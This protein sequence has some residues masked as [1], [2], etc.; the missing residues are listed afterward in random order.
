MFPAGAP[1]IALLVL[2]NCI[3]IALAG[4]AFPVGWQHA[5]FLVLLSMLCFGLFT[6]VV[7]G[8][9]VAALLFHPAHSSAVFS[10]NIV[11]LALSALSLALLG[12]GAFSIDARIFGRRVLVSTASSNSDDGEQE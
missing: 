5:A 6:P 10:A 12:P 7:C 8:I 3:A 9:A 1:G 2:R 4:S 11:I